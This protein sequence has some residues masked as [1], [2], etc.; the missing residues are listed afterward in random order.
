MQS[1]LFTGTL[2]LLKRRYDL[3]A[4]CS[5]NNEFSIKVLQYYSLRNNFNIK[6]FAVRVAKKL[7]KSNICRLR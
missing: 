1:Q 5:S 4:F 3:R 6:H 7:Y 2:L